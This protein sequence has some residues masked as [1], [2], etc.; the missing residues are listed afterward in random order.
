MH[1]QTQHILLL[2]A[3]S[4]EGMSETLDLLRPSHSRARRPERQPHPR[5]GQGPAVV[6]TKDPRPPPEDR[7]IGE[8]N[9][10]IPWQGLLC[11]LSRPKCEHATTVF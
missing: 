11:A 4:A 10:V 2:A 8:G 7:G 5:G 6:G 3:A 1:A 9:A